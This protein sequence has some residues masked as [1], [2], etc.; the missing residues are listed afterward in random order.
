MYHGMRHHVENPTVYDSLFS[1]DSPLT[2]ID[3]VDVIL[4]GSDLNDGSC[5]IRGEGSTDIFLLTGFP[6]TGVMRYLIRTFETFVAFGFDE[7]LVRE[8]P[9][10][11]LQGIRAGRPIEA[12]IENGK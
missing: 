8:I 4:R 7:H 5:L 10:L 9:D 2:Q 12:N 11:V 6:G 1:S 3:T